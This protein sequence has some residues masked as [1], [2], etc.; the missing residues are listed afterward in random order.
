MVTPSAQQLGALRLAVQSQRRA[1]S[2]PQKYK[3]QR[4]FVNQN[5]THLWYGA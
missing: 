2:V 4:F 5:T 3:K 1:V